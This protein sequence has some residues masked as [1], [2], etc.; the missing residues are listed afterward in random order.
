MNTETLE[1][2]A[3]QGIR[4]TI[5]APR[6]ASKVRRKASRKWRDVSGGRIDPSRVC[7]ASGC[8]RAK[9]I[10]VFFYD[11]PISQAVA[12]EGILSDGQRFADRLMGGFSDS[13]S[14][15]QLM[16]IATDGES[17]GHHHHY[18][19]MAL[20]YA[21]RHIASNKLADLTNYG[22]FLEKF[23]PD[24]FA[25][26]VSDSSWSCVHGIL[27]AGGPIAAAIPDAGMETGISSGENRYGMLSIGCATTWRSSMSNRAQRC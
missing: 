17:Y 20:S 9:T 1:V 13:R 3:E 15:A 25:E 5:L 22:Q 19:E 6:Q 2:L 8:H 4:F 18:G 23:P 27:S 7:G 16:H 26:V 11:G 21:L 14:W 24:Q 12:F 10:N